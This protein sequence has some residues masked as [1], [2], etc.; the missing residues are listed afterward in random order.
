MVI[1]M[2]LSETHSVTVI[3]NDF[4]RTIEPDKLPSEG[5]NYVIYDSADGNS[6]RTSNYSYELGAG[7]DLLEVSGD[8]WNTDSVKEQVFFGGDGDDTLIGVIQAIG[9]TMATTRSSRRRQR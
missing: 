3:D 2:G 5:N 8:L 4:Q 7:D 1:L 6:A 9:G